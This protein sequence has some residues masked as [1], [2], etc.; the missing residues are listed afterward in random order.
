MT[1][2]RLLRFLEERNKALTSLDQEYVARM[3]PDAPATMRLLILHKAR[4]E[5]TAIEA[6]LRHESGAWLREHG[7]NRMS[8]DP[9]LP[10]GELPE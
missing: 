1:D 9:I 6:N 7:F 4:Y 5:C 2:T 10:D 8:G 3:L